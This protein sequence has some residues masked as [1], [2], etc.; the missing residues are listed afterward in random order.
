MSYVD[1]RWLSVP[2]PTNSPLTQTKP[3][4]FAAP[5][6]SSVRRPRHAAGTVNSRRYTPVG[7]S[8]GTCGACPSNGIR[9]LR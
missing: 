9:T 6:R 1:G 4:E 5:T 7:L 8:A 3:I 2:N